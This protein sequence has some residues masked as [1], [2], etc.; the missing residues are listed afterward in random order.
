MTDGMKQGVERAFAWSGVPFVLAFA[1]GMVLFA[2]FVP[3]PAPSASAEEVAQAYREDGTTIRTGVLV[4][5]LGLTFFY[6]WGAVV[7]RQT[8]RITGASPVVNQC[9]AAALA[10]SIMIMVFSCL[11]WWTAAYRPD[12]RSPETTQAL[13]DLAWI[14]F[15]AG[16]I[17]YVV[18]A[19][20]I[21]LAILSDDEVRPLYPRWI[22]YCSFFAAISLTTSAF[23]PFFKTG[24][25]A[26][27][28]VAGFWLP[29]CDFFLWVVVMIVFT[30]RAVRTPH[31]S[32]PRSVATRIEVLP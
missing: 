22:G 15:V 6:T 12:T 5:Y 7:Q 31:R 29:L 9:Q 25:F 16:F 26:W 28:G 1:V 11:F 23:L 18:W 27:N 4:C 32:E 14:T 19:L 10:G 2:Q 30:E 3:P 8:K 17:P 24:P 13:H 20:A 21:G